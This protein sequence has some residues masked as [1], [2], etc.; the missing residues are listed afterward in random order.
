MR[1]VSTSRA[2]R[3]YELV[4]QYASFGDHRTGTPAD[5]ATRDWFAAALHARGARVELD[6]YTFDRY[7]AEATVLVDGHP[8]RCLPVF[9]SG[10][11]RVETDD[12]ALRGL[13]TGGGVGSAPNEAIDAALAEARHEARAAVVFATD[14]PDG[15]LIAVN[16][17]VGEPRG[18]LAV[19]VAGRELP[20][21]HDGHVRVVGRAH[22]TPGSSANVL[23]RTGEPD[24]PAVLVTTPLTGWFA[25]AGERGTG[26]AVAL[27]LVSE[28]SRW[29]SLEVVGTTGHELGFLGLRHHLQERRP[30]R[31][32]VIVHLGAGVAAGDGPTRFGALRVA[33]V[34]GPRPQE[35]AALGDVLASASLTP[36]AWDTVPTEALSEGAEWRAVAAG[37]GT[38]VLSVLGWF[39]QFHTPDDVTETVTAPVLLE[40][41]TDALVEAIRMLLPPRTG[42][43]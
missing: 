15:R 40:R 36:I 27:E 41:V 2:A 3:L 31:A 25:C 32:D 13:T 38:T 20:A 21:L 26:A 12:V 24:G 28:L 39:P 37:R 34:D 43:E 9:Y 22:T 16:R 30:A 11:G 6:P 23:A 14:P 17:P 18:P 1:A 8:L 4:Q 5:D 42:A 10:V 19:F 33:L 7:E 29:A 35:L